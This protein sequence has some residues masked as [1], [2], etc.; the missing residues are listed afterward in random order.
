M[1][2]IEFN[3]CPNNIGSFEVV[4]EHQNFKEYLIDKIQLYPL[5]LYCDI[6]WYKMLKPYDISIEPA[7]IEK[8]LPLS[9]EKEIK[10][11]IPNY[12]NLLTFTLNKFIKSVVDALLSWLYEEFKLYQ[13]SWKQLAY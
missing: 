10:L 13:D 12:I 4:I 5:N 1:W 9:L 2:Y 8:G 11:H 7:M 3:M 6:H